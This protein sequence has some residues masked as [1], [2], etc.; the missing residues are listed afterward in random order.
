MALIVTI[1]A[2]SKLE[3]RVELL[4]A[5]FRR[6]S[7][8]IKS[9]FNRKHGGSNFE[10][11]ELHRNIQSSA[12]NESEENDGSDYDN[13]DMNG[14]MFNGDSDLDNVSDIDTHDDGGHSSSI[15]HSAGL[16]LITLKERYRLTQV[17][18]DFAIEQ[19][20]RALIVRCMLRMK[21]KA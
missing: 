6:Y 20:Q 17:A 13:F 21:W 18:V 8:I 16:F 15:E 4:S 19:V 9:H 10:S 7:A 5:N 2:T 1:N 14:N 11:V 3:I 12:R